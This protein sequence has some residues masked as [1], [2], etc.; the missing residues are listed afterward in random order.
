MNLGGEG[1][2][3]I[4]AIPRAFTSSHCPL[5][6][7]H[8]QPTGWL[9]RGRSRWTASTLCPDLFPLGSDEGGP[10][11]GGPQAR[12][13]A[14][15]RLPALL[16]VHC[17]SQTHSFPST[18]TWP[19]PSPPIGT[20]HWPHGPSMSLRPSLYPIC[21]SGQ[22]SPVMDQRFLT[23]PHP[24]LDSPSVPTTHSTVLTRQITFNSPFLQNWWTRL[25]P[26]L[27]TS[28]AGMTVCICHVLFKEHR[29]Y[30]LI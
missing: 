24:T 3:T 17:L 19:E 30:H 12:L 9:N 16:C 18:K 10:V 23:L 4:Q 7:P 25:I 27:I 2:Y 21:N 22:A 20:L 29:V 14:S 15:P 5:S 1:R 26:C 13:S 8:S 11:R 6:P 28:R